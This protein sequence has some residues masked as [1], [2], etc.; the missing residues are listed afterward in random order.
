MSNLSAIK[1]AITRASTQVAKTGRQLARSTSTVASTLIAELRGVSVKQQ[2]PRAIARTQPVVHFCAHVV[3]LGVDIPPAVVPTPQ[4]ITLASRPTPEADL[5]RT[6]EQIEIDVLCDDLELLVDKLGAD[7]EKMAANNVND[8]WDSTLA[9]LGV[10]CVG[11]GITTDKR[12]RSDPVKV[13]QQF[14]TLLKELETQQELDEVASLLDQLDRENAAMY[15]Q[16]ATSQTRSMAPVVAPSHRKAELLLNSST[17]GL[18]EL[19]HE[20]SGGAANK[21]STP[22][23]ITTSAADR[24]ETDQVIADL[25]DAFDAFDANQPSDPI[26][27][28]AEWQALLK[29]LD[30]AD[31]ATPALDLQARNARKMLDDSTEALTA[32]MDGLKKDISSTRTGFVAKESEMQPAAKTGVAS[33]TSTAA[34]QALVAEAVP[35]SS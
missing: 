19:M 15:P 23:G 2:K 13:D 18:T 11:G 9:T 21:I 4:P 32:L 6:P 35:L 33:H 16:R 30:E 34:P 27:V 10:A 29:E 31:S 17:V 5:T 1:R 14:E 12:F 20:L 26:K 22:S 7:I 24:T 8:P 25:E 3:K 28:D